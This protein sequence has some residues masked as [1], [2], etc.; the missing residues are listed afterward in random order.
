M[1]SLMVN[2]AH[3]GV[4][5][6]D[7]YPDF[8]QE[9]L[10]NTALRD[11]FLDALAML[12][13]ADKGLLEELPNT[14]STA[15]DFLMKSPARSEN[16]IKAGRT[17]LMTWKRTVE[18]LQILFRPPEI[19][20]RADPSLTDDSWF[21]LLK[22]EFQTEQA[23]YAVVLECALLEH[24]PALNTFIDIAVTFKGQEKLD[25][26]PLKATLR[27]GTYQEIL[28][29]EAEGR[30]KFGEI[31]LSIPFDDAFEEIVADLDFSLEAA[32]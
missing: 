29:I 28:L 15:L 10:S 1:L 17:W 2:E 4:N 16:S 19:A 25:L 31:P 27:W 18:D 11:A 5:L 21:T 26:F 24:Q 12:E 13:K 32:S 23:Q 14:P 20:Y 30:L 7:Q 9:L 22:E 6:T 3:K 8:Y